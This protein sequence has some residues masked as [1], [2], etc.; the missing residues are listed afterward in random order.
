MII[1][2]T[3]LTQKR[4]KFKSVQKSTPRKKLAD[5]SP[6]RKK[7]KRTKHILLRDMWYMVMTYKGVIWV[8]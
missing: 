8:R 5:S 3:L 1:A 7:I 6:F 2:Q 4:G